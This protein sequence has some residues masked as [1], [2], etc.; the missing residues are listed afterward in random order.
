MEN[1]TDECISP[2]QGQQAFRV[3]FEQAGFG[4]AQVSLEGEW[5]T[6]N[7]SLCEILGYSREELL[8]KTLPEITRF[9]DVANELA[10]CRRLLDNQIQSF[11]SEKRHL[12]GDGRVAWLKA[13]I[14]LVRENASGEPASYLAVVEDLTPHKKHLQQIL[15]DGD[16]RFRVL[17]DSV[18]EVFLALDRN[19]RCTY[20]N[21]TAESVFGVR[22]ADAVGKPVTEIVPATGDTTS[23]EKVYREVLAAQQIRSFTAPYKIGD[24]KLLLEFTAYPSKEGISVFASDVGERRR[25]EE[26]LQRLA[27]IVQSSDDAIL[28][29]T[30][31]GCIASWNRGAERL[32]GYSASEIMGK[33]V[34]VL[35]PPHLLG[36][37][38]SIWQG[39]FAGNGVQ[40]HETQRVRKDGVAVEVSLSISPVRNGNG[41]IAA[42]SFIARDISERKRTEAALRRQVIFNELM[43]RVLIRFTTCRSSEVRASVSAALAETAEFLGVDHA[44][45][46]IFSPDRATW[47]A[48]HEWCGTQVEPQ[49]ANY[50]AVPFGSVPWSESQVL[51]G[52]VIRINTL[53]DYPAEAVAE[54]QIADVQAGMQSI[55]LV[56]IHGAAGVIA[57]AV[58]FDSHARPV[59]WSDDDVAHCK[60]VGDAIATVLERKRAEEALRNSEEKFS[61]AFEASPAIITILRIKDR[62][63]LEVNR[64]FEQHTGFL[65]TE[66]LRKSI[67]EVGRWSDLRSLNHAFEKVLAQGSVRNLEATL[68]TKSGESLI[69]LLSA[70]VI[71]FDGQS[72]VLTVAEDI[73]ERKLAEDALRESEERFRVMADSAPI[74]MWMAGPDKSCTD[75]NRGWLEFRGRTL[76]QESGDGWIAGVHPADLQK[77]VNTYHTAFDKRQPFIMEYRLRRH[78]GEYRWVTDTGVPRFLLDGSFVGYIGCCIDIDDQKQTELART[79]LSR[80]LMTAQEAE[81]TR[82]ARELHDGIGQALALLGIQMQTA[83]QPAAL[84][85]GKKNPGLQELCG[86]LKEIG[87]QVSRLSHQL[88]SSE[89]EFL[90]LAV[91]VKSLCREFSE[92]YRIKVECVCSDIPEELNNDVA[93]SFLRIVQEALHNVAKHSHATVVHVEVGG[94]SHDLAL[95]IWDDG[96][97][98]DLSKARKTA[99]LGMVS[100]RER[101]HLIGGEFSI[102]SQPGSGTKIQARAPLAPQPI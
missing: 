17:A 67:A 36:E 102:A 40:G 55:L 28:S 21:R 73:T 88:H 57:G 82:I 92:Q 89:L 101:M 2:L 32:F 81:R 26:T 63:Y 50:R 34:D 31:Q 75:F 30:P 44:H 11:S 41:S 45:V 3:M 86:K 98:F 19:L 43:T 15:V 99:G 20:W 18:S 39:A 66:V 72:C 95:A 68:R 38:Q 7:Q 93:L 83:S 76:Q 58:G 13:T 27:A 1:L 37:A 47:T 23:S 87:N 48:T 9:D 100:M 46:L 79:E 53:D 80:R 94:V 96:V 5:L 16:K 6:V 54:R 14:T 74:M 70:E 77:C 91:A 12:R 10:D 29:V 56:P 59:N 71:E 62:R 35:V 49:S 85:L 25:S 33:K 22:A 52:Q 51:A 4:L 24:K 60:M 65:R 90:G 78:D 42:I 84:R 64:A 61:K 97:G 8:A 69:V